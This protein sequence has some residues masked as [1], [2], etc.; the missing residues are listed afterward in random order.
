MITKPTT[1]EKKTDPPPVRGNGSWSL[2]NT[3]TALGMGG[4]V[5]FVI[6]SVL[7]GTLQVQTG[8]IDALSSK[9]VSHEVLLA[10]TNLRVDTLQSMMSEVRSILSTISQHINDISA[11]IPARGKR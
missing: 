9:S 6:G 10:T 8:R 7:W 4:A 5:I 11:R 1:P 3:L 2:G